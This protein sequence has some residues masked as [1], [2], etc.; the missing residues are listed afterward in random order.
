MNTAV[1]AP[2]GVVKPWNQIDWKRAEAY[3]RK[4]QTRIV[5]AHQEGRHNK[6]KALQWLLTHSFYGKAL[7]VK[8]VTGNQGKKTAG[9]DS[10]L[11]R[12][13]KQK[14]E[15][16]QDLK[17]RGYRPMPLRRVYIPK[18]NGKMRPLSIPTMRDR[19]MQTL[20]KYALE[21]IAEITADPNSYGFRT[22]RCVEDAIEQCFTCL[23]KAKSPKWVLEG[24]IKGCFDNISHEWIM[25]NIPM[26]KGV[27]HKWLKCGYVETNKLFP[28]E[29]GAP[30]GSPISPVICNMVLDGL[31]RKI[32]EKYYEGWHKGIW[33]S[34][35]VNYVRYADDFI[36]TGESKDTLEKG[37][38]PIIREFL[39]ER[40]LELSEE[41]T[42]ITHIADGFDFLGS[43]IKMYKN[44]LLIKPSKKNYKAI[45]SKIR[46]IIKKC[47]TWKQEDLIWKLNPIIRG[48]VNFH[49]H[50]VASD[51][52]RH[53]DHDIWKSLWK[54][55]CHRHPKKNHRWIAK[56]YFHQVN[57]KSWI[58]AVAMKDGSLLKLTSAS[59]TKIVRFLKTKAE[60][61][62]FD[63]K[64]DSYFE[65]RDT[66]RMSREIKGKHKLNALFKQQKG[67]C[68]CCGRRITVDKGYLIHHGTDSNY[69]V[70]SILVH[71]ECDK[72][73][74]AKDIGDE[75]VPITRGL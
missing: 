49:K 19:A 71:S 51:A 72:L 41:K 54:W 11:W 68:P 9:V 70:S 47:S 30:Q 33:L 4:L 69:K 21:P 39:G 2:P 38:L 37:V 62:P 60:A 57:G 6:V 15:A 18:K 40:G 25:N 61:T 31:E 64:W 32:K 27:L 65:E 14:F 29:Q 1:C 50:K 63:P 73:L 58:F 34:P 10:E 16:I 67:L 48:W 17:R 75:L 66:I 52:F 3:V 56:K 43:N 28:T 55:C 24:D 42:V 74:H 53:L 35:K 8:R 20:Y 23:N 13:P 44:K 5:K 46:D 59:D 22:A 45:V 12:T 36:V 7:A 26:D